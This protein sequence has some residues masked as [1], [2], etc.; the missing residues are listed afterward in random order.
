MIRTLL[1]LPL[2]LG[3]LL[4]GGVFA[5][6]DRP[7]VIQGLEPQ[8]ALHNRI[9]RDAIAA[10]AQLRDMSG[11]QWPGPQRIIWVEDEDVF[12]A[13]TG[14]RAEHTAAA[15]HPARQIIWINASAWNRGAPANQR[16][17]LTHEMA[18]VFIGSLPG[19]QDLPLW[20]EEGLVQRLAGQGGAEEVLALAK[21]RLFGGLPDL[22]ELEH[23]FPRDPTRQHL[24][25]ALSYQSVGVVAG[26]IGRGS[27][28]NLVAE[29]AHPQLGP[30]LS[31]K[32]WNEWSRDRWN[33]EALDLIGEPAE[34]AVI[35]FA[36]GTPFWVFIAVVAVIGYALTK[37]RQRAAGQRENDEEPWMESL[38]QDDVQDVW[39]DREERWQTEETPWER[40]E[41]ERDDANRGGY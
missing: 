12:R 37:R 36:T 30:L 9:E 17:T 41:R 14:F 34:N 13:I 38:T 5:Q 24:S 16:Q 25:Y 35:V 2:L 18:H 20:F 19:G 6:G 33:E 27:A 21:G 8:S 39:G 40:H 32:L 3:W 29:L 31:E 22:R 7:L 1:L 10:R 15:A 11:T 4:A 23:S 26:D 28:A